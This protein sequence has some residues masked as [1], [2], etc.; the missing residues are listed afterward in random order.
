MTVAQRNKKNQIKL[1]NS[2]AKFNIS[3][4]KTEIC[5]EFLIY[6]TKL[7]HDNFLG[8]D[9]FESEAELDTYVSWCFGKTCEKIKKI[10]NFDFSIQ[11]QLETY[12]IIYSKEVLKKLETPNL[13]LKLINILNINFN[14]Y[15]ISTDDDIENFLMLY[16]KFF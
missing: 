11:K 1:N 10:Y 13:I 7:V 8:Y 16:H 6:L 12:C 5:R 3:R 9:A 15:L 14:I 2:L 4:E